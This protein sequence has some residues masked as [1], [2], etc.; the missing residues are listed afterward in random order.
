[1]TTPVCQRG[2]TIIE[3]LAAMLLIG[4]VIPVAMTAANIALR[5]AAMVRHRHEAT[6]LAEQK[7]SE[8]LA[9]RDVAA[10]G[11][12]G[13]FEP[14]WDEYRW[15]LS[16]EQADFSIVNVTATVF[17][18]EREVERSMSLTTLVFPKPSDE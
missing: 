13:P 17:W 14:P 1:M 8:I 2:F 15:E 12:G 6:M 7:L 5:S 10:A 18:T 9:V 4:I 11:T 3:V 16:T